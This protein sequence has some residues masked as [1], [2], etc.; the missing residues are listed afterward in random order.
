[1][2]VSEDDHTICNYYN[3]NKCVSNEKYRICKENVLF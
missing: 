3:L 2:N 1:M